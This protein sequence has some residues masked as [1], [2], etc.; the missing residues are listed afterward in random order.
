MTAR[1]DLDDPRF[2]A[3]GDPGGMLAA[4]ETFHRQCEE[5][6]RL[7]EGFSELPAAGKIKE[8]CFIGMGG[9]G[10]GGD[11]LRSL[12]AEQGSGLSIRVHKD[13]GLP[14]GVGAETLV[15]AT[16]YSGNTEETLSGFEEATARGCVILGVSSGGALQEM[17]SRRGVPCILV[18]GGLQPRAALGYLTLPA[19]VVLERMGL[20]VGFSRS[21]RRAVELME[22]KGQRWRPAQPTADNEAKRIAELMPGKIPLVYGA[23]GPLQ[24]SAYR[25]KCQFNENAKDPAFYNALPE[26]NHNELAGWKVADDLKNSFVV[27]ILVDEDADARIARKVRITSQILREHVSAVEVIAIGGETHMERM[28]SAIHLGDY[29]SVYLALLKGVDPTPVDVITL[30]KKKLA[31]EERAENSRE[32]GDEPHSSDGV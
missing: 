9:S 22:R 32:N 30:L 13:Y 26:M 1:Q 21:S 6:L 18:P 24:V 8:L 15:V 23:G 31:E 5:A 28:L 12:L 2:L 16:S 29:V 4:V 7:G 25:W 10:I 14:A 27:V 3:A 20:L 11:M 17:T 19:G